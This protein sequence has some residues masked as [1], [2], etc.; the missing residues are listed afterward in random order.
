VL[1]LD[2]TIETNNQ[3]EN[4]VVFPSCK[5][6]FT[7]PNHYEEKLEWIKLSVETLLHHIQELEDIRK[8]IAVY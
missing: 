3:G 7:A 8:A 1:T 6:D 4:V 2:V 5:D